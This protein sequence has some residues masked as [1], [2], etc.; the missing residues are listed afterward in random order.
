VSDLDD[1]LKAFAHL[2]DRDPP[3]ALATQLAQSVLARR[4][5]VVEA[6]LGLRF[7]LLPIG[8]GAAAM[9]MFAVQALDRVRV[10]D[11]LVP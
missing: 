7:A 4:R 2:T 1:G 11:V 9:V 10:L 3:L 6:L 8:L 5:S